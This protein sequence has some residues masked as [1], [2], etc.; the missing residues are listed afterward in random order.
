MVICLPNTNT[1]NL[2]VSSSCVTLALKLWG[3]ASVSAPST[4]EK[5]VFSSP[6]GPFS[7]FET[8]ILPLSRVLGV[9]GWVTVMLPRLPCL[10]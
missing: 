7:A 4:L 5:L 6:N 10:S 1:S 3:A 2:S 9:K 8:N